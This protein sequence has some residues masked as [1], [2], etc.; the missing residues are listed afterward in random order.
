ML[1]G[2][3]AASTTVTGPGAGWPAPARPGPA[4][5]RRR[6]RR[7]ARDEPCGACAVRR[8]GGRHWYCASASR[9]PA[10]LPERRLRRPGPAPR[11][12]PPDGGRPVGRR[13]PAP[14][15]RPVR[16]WSSRVASARPA[17]QSSSSRSG[18]P[19]QSASA[20][21][22]TYAARSCSPSDEQLEAAADQ[23]LEAMRIDLVGR[24]REPVARRRR[25][26]GGAA[27]HLAQAGP[28]SP[29]RTLCH[30]GGGCSAHSASA[31]RSGVTTSPG[32]SA[33]TSSTTRS[34]GPSDELSP[35]TVNGPSTAMVTQ[36][37]SGRP[38]PARQWRCYR[39]VT[40][41]DPLRT[42][43][44]DNR[45]LGHSARSDERNRP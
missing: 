36:A 40:A 7:R 37:V 16:S 1:G 35:S 45:A 29:A 20:S 33:S 5:A 14:P 11:R 22:L 42:A 12:A 18:G 23:P 43:G 28:R 41:P 9:R 27:Q 3:S 32:R 8:P 10:A 25:L 24:D 30:V 44:C 38:S 6:A 13:R 21:P 4:Q 31:S 26:D 39:P 15:R 34:R 17:S 19:R 2:G